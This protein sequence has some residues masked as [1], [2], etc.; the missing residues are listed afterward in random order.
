MKLPRPFAVKDWTLGHLSLVILAGVLSVWMLGALASGFSSDVA[1]PDGD[2]PARSVPQALNF[3]AGPDQPELTPGLVNPPVPARRAPTPGYSVSCDN[4][5]AVP[6]LSTASFSC[7]VLSTGGF[8]ETVDLTCANLPRALAC[9]PVPALIT[10]PPNGSATFQ[11]N[12]ANTGVAPGSH[13]FKVVGTAGTAN[14]SFT[15]PFD[16]TGESPAPAASPPRTGKV[17]I[18]C[19]TGSTRLIPGQTISYKCTFTSELFNG[20][21]TTSCVGTKGIACEISPGTVA[22]RDGAPAESTLTLNVAPNLTS[23]GLNQ[24]IS[25]FGDSVDLGPPGPRPVKKFTVD[26]PP[27]DY[28]LACA[29][30]SIQIQAGA[31]GALTCKVSSSTGY[32]GPLYVKAA[33]VEAGGPGVVVTP[34]SVQVG[35]RTS[36]DSTVTFDVPE[37]STPGA[38]RYLLGIFAEP[39]TPFA[40]AGPDSDRQLTLTLSVA[41]PPSPP[42]PEPSP[43]PTAAGP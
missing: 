7:R 38:Y 34:P 6:R 39:D 42:A 27:P 14:S 4:S 30:Q 37:G 31:T 22:P 24:I 9:E 12:L 40:P 43:S 8:S 35:L 19:Q 26:V 18:Q 36:V 11:L 23:A 33:G 15:F 16:T 28:S 2:T 41:P 3:G 5:R 20:S 17:D 32:V 1:E 25:V 13:S 10:P 29:E 21:V